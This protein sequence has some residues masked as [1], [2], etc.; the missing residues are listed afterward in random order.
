M[1]YVKFPAGY[2]PHTGEHDVSVNRDFIYLQPRDNPDLRIC[3]D[4]KILALQETL[5]KKK[6][7]V[8][9]LEKQ[10]AA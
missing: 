8:A 10:I 9:E 7:E 4:R 6:V 2:K 1:I 3:I 5:R